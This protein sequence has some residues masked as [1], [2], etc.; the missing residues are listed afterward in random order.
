MRCYFLKIN[1]IFV[2]LN[3]LGTVCVCVCAFINEAESTVYKKAVTQRATWTLCPVTP[4]LT[5]LCRF[6]CV[7]AAHRWPGSRFDQTLARGAGT[8]KR[9]RVDAAFTATGRKVA[10]Q[11]RGGR[12]LLTSPGR[13]PIVRGSTSRSTERA[14]V[15]IFFVFAAPGPDCRQR[16]VAVRLYCLLT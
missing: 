13:C 5:L 8:Q 14:S 9:A 15:S 3:D 10:A 2:F 16:A 11:Q 12:L 1:F 7:S 4:P 6:T